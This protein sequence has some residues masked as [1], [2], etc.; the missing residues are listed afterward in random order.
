MHVYPSKI[1][2]VA[3]AL[4]LSATVATAQRPQVGLGGGASLPTGDLSEEQGSGFHGLVTMGYRPA[5]YPIGFRL[6][7]M[8]HK[9]DAEA[10]SITLPASEDLRVLAFTGN[11]VLELPGMAVKPY[12]IGGGGLYNTKFV[13]SEN[14]F[15]VNGGA[16]LKFRFMD[17]DTFIEARYHNIFDALGAGDNA[18][19]AVFVPIT[20][21]VSF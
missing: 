10:R 16:G 2:A 12:F 11:V 5:M 13:E 18:R 8:Y 3:L 9:L 15:G 17:F 14:N 6:D 20:F 4:S 19:S 1:A 7:G 21:G